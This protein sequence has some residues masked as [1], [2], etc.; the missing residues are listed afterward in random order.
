MVLGWKE[1]LGKG[2][3]MRGWGDGLKK[4]F[5]KLYHKLNKVDFS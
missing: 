4:G 3:E 1:I 5:V 2:R